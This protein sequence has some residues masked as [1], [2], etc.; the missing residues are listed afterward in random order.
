MVSASLVPE[1]ELW[2]DDFTSLLLGFPTPFTTDMVPDVLLPAARDT[3]VADQKQDDGG[4]AMEDP[5]KHAHAS[6]KNRRM[7]IVQT[8]HARPCP[9]RDDGIWHALNL[10]WLRRKD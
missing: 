8:A 3:H 4:T 9:K 2:A 5:A 7:S 10:Q 6:N 1:A